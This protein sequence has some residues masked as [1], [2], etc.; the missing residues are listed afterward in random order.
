MSE[1]KF[2][3][4]LTN[5][6]QGHQALLQAWSFAKAWLMSGH[7][8]SLTI[9]RE[10]RTTAQNRL[11]WSILGDLSTQVRWAI[12]GASGH[13]SADDWKIMLTASLK[14]E[15]RITQGID[16]GLVLLGQSTSKMTVKEMS[17]LIELAY[18]FGAQHE[19]KW[20]KTSLSR[21]DNEAEGV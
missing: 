3:I 13:L 16:G 1:E 6:Q 18:A 19:V 15:Q 11:M 12:G 9:R 2:T 17:E 14:K 4:L 21:E 5:A 20:S 10:T 7:R 8:L